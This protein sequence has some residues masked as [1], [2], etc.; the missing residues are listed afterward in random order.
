M[1][2]LNKTYLLKNLEKLIYQRYIL[3]EVKLL[4]N[5]IVPNVL[6][7]DSDNCLYDPSSNSCLKF[8]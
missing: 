5:F 3:E 7:T 8:Y 4:G 6:L 1:T 2:Y